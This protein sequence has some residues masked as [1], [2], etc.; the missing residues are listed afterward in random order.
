MLHSSLTNYLF[1]QTAVNFKC[2]KV[3]GVFQ[4]RKDAF[5]G[6]AGVAD[7]V[8]SC[9]QAV[10]QLLETLTGCVRYVCSL[11]ELSLQSIH[12]LPSSVLWVVKSTFTHCKVGTAG[13]TKFLV[14]LGFQEAL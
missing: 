11:Q 6:I 10:V 5:G 9:S 13:S 12:S 2:H 4:L 8:P 3:P 14:L 1:M 7:V